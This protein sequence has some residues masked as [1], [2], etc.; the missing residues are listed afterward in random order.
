MII[1]RDPIVEH[2]RMDVV[3]QILDRK[4]PSVRRRGGRGSFGGRRAALSKIGTGDAVGKA[5]KS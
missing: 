1:D 5:G 3:R 4:I 2:V